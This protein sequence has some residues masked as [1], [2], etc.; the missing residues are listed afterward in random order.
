MENENVQEN[1]E[2]PPTIEDLKNKKLEMNGL[3]LLSLLKD[4]EVKLTFFDPQYRGVLDKM[5]YGNEGERQSGRASLE[6]MS[7][8]V[9]IEFIKEIDRV[10]A[11]S[12]HL[13]LWVD[14][15]HLCE[16]VKPWV[17]GTNLNLVDML[18]WDKGRIGMGY[19]T[20][21]KAEYLIIFQKSPIR[22]KGCWLV[23]DIPDTWLEKVQKV[24][25]HSKPIQLQSALIN[26]TTHEGDL[27][28]D[29]ASGGFSVYEA[30]QLINRDF[31]GCDLKVQ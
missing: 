13:M 11:P 30:C 4:G 18:T 12:G 1:I 16:G 21:R 22:A 28:L 20:R 23:H 17:K 8:D 25:P 6:Q 5:K 26:A 15:F 27:V 31:I 2:I 19:R 3:E 14:K 10:L 7:E 9:I 24:H 29:P